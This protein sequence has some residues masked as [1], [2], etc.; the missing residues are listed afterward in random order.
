MQGAGR[1]KI[2]SELGAGSFSVT[3]QATDRLRNVEVAIKVEKQ[4]KARKILR[5]EYEFLCKM[6]GF[7]HVI[8]VH[9]FVD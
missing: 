5:S 8:Q 4:D 9:E 6:T 7:E 1:Y 3:Y 2:I